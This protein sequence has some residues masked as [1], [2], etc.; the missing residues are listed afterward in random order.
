MPDA[1]EYKIGE[2]NAASLKIFLGT[3]KDSLVPPKCDF[4]DSSDPQ[5]FL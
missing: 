5:D 4:L 3:V 1:V 2:E